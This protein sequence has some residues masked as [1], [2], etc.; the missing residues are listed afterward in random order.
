[1]YRTLYIE[2][3]GGPADGKQISYTLL[4]ERENPIHYRHQH[5]GMWLLYKWDP[6]SLGE[7][8][9]LV[10]RFLQDITETVQKEIEEI[11]RDNNGGD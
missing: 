5:M 9:R 10:Y 11:Y 3:V 6:L 8:G 1:M 4:S 7:S 2:F